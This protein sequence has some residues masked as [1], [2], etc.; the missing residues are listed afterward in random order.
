MIRVPVK[1]KPGVYRIMRT[2]V[3]RTR[4]FARYHEVKKLSPRL[5]D[6]IYGAI[7][8]TVQYRPEESSICSADLIKR[9]PRDGDSEASLT[10]FGDS[11]QLKNSL[12][13]QV[14]WTYIFDQTDTWET[15]WPDRRRTGAHYVRLEP[16][17]RIEP[18]GPAPSQVP[19]AA[20]TSTR[21][22]SLE[23]S[24]ATE[25]QP[26]D[27]VEIIG[28]KYKD[29]EFL[30]RVS[31]IEMVNGFP[32]ATLKLNLNGRFVDV[33]LFRMDEIKKVDPPRQ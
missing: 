21:E 20:T 22:I 19:F 13:E 16:K 29:Y 27:W 12:F 23:P 31:A 25:I 33:R 17:S 6:E 11:E 15:T 3:P 18:P 8:R 7:S 26:G 30:A 1:T 14:L 5:I 28:G 9:M 24:V 4:T 10:R 2:R 32:K